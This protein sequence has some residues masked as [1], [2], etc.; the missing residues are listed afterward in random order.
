M[1]KNKNYFTSSACSG[2]IVL[3]KVNQQETKHGSAF[4][5]KWH[6]TTTTQKIWEAL[7]KKT[8]DEIWFKQEPF[9]LHIGCKGIKDAKILLAAAKECGIK[10]AGINAATEG[11]FILELIGTQNIAFPAKK[12][13]TIIFEKKQLEYIVKRANEKLEK[14]YLLLEKFESHCRKKIK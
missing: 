3:L 10:R 4:I 11:K 13:D 1:S 2:R 9:I 6:S 7:S 12:D 5:A 8:E 14:N